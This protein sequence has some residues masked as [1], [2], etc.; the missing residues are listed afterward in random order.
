MTKKPVVRNWRQVTPYVGHE[1]AIIWPI[2]RGGEDTAEL[3][4]EE[5]PMLDM[6]GFTIHR[7][8]GGRVR[9]LPRSRRPRAGLLLHLR[10]G[11]D[12]ARRRDIRSPG[13]G[14]RPHPAHG[15]AP[16]D[17]RLRRLD[18]T[19][20]GHGPRTHVGVPPQSPPYEKVA[21]PVACVGAC[22]GHLRFWTTAGSCLASIEAARQRSH[23][24][25]RTRAEPCAGHSD[26]MLARPANETC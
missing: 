2:F 16:T 26:C 4:D 23:G 6:V 11:K 1:S 24:H 10:P 22:D 20:V 8:Q 17:K 18:R 15:Q 25:P 14:R 12:E 5:A 19:P 21:R 9:R 7:M 3:S 13:R